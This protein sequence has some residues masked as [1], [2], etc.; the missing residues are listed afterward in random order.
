MT[1]R[2][3]LL[4]AARFLKEAGVPNPEHDASWMLSYL[5]GRGALELR[6]D[7]DGEITGETEEAFLKLLKRRQNREPLQYITGSTVFCGNTFLTDSR[8]L[9]PR[10]ETEELVEWALEENAGKSGLEVLDLCCGSGCIGLSI[11]KKSD[12]RVTLAD[13]SNDALTLAKENAETIG[14]T[15]EERRLS[16]GD[17]T[18]AGENRVTVGEETARKSRVEYL[19]GDLFEPVGN[20]RFDLI[21]SNPPYIPSEECERLQEEVLWEPKMALD[22]GTD[23]L[24]FY[25]RI[26]EKAQEHLKAGGLLMMEMGDGEA[27]SISGMLREREAKRVVI[28]KDFAGIERMILA[29]FG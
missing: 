14:T 27:E 9:I 28:R 25:R 23:G 18:P 20:R 16:K 6:A 4:S 8:G 2:A 3:L 7:M 24:V 26:A 12:A 19:L 5:T 22:G 11:W 13:A 1:P 15:E 29:E 17:S 10:P 21:I